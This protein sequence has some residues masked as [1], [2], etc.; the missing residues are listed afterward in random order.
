MGVHLKLAAISETNIEQLLENPRLIWK[1]IFPTET[2][3]AAQL[4]PARIDLLPEQFPIHE[5]LGEYWHA[6]HYLLSGQVWSGIMPEAFL[7]DGGSFIGSVDVGYGPARI[8]DIDETKAIAAMLAR[9]QPA[10]LAELFN[11]LRMVDVDIYPQIWD[12]N[13]EAFD[14]CL[15]YFKKLQHFMRHAAENER[16]LVVY[17]T[18]V[19]DAE[20]QAA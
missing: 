6:L 11:P 14:N 17:L 19:A 16:G 1:V 3:Q 18:K 8:F 5:T 20:Q 7:L 2:H 13:P 15:H 9:K 10:D 4:S 12:S